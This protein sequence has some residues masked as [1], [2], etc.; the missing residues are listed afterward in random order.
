MIQ[1]MDSIPG[2]DITNVDPGQPG[3]P[4]QFGIWR[5]HSIFEPQ[6]GD[7]RSADTILNRDD[8]NLE[9]RIKQKVKR[10]LFDGDDKI[11]EN[12]LKIV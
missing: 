1:A 8:E 6:T 2:I 7:R 12:R 5:T 9:V 11:H 10:I 4:P 3:L